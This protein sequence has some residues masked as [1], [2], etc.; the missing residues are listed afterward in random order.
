MMLTLITTIH[1]PTILAL[2]SVA[3][4]ASGLRCSVSRVSGTEKS[5]DSVVVDCKSLGLSEVR[6]NVYFS[7]EMKLVRTVN[8]CKYICCNTFEHSTLFVRIICWNVA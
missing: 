1:L 3:L 6:C 4:F 5:R 2:G 8:D 7:V